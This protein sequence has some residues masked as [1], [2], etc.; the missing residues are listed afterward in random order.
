MWQHKELHEMF[1]RNGLDES[2]FYCSTTGTLSSS[3]SASKMSTL[4][5]SPMGESATVC[6]IILIV[7][8]SGVLS[9]KIMKKLLK[10]VQVQGR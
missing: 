7:Y 8:N 6:F 10:I 9:E 5:H 1:R 4:K 2:H 3:R